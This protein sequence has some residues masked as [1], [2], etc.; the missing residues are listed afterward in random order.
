MSSLIYFFPRKK[1]HNFIQRQNYILLVDYCSTCIY[2]I[3]FTLHSGLSPESAVPKKRQHKTFQIFTRRGSGLHP[4]ICTGKFYDI[5]TRSPKKKDSRET[6][7]SECTAAKSNRK[8]LR[9]RVDIRMMIEAVCAIWPK[10]LYFPSVLINPHRLLRGSV[11][12]LVLLP[13][14]V[15]KRDRV[16]NRF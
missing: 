8:K 3:D 5:Y 9:P 1:N 6:Q 2:A 11:G 12:L 16:K 7:K 13:V 4:K 14:S 10:L 15:N